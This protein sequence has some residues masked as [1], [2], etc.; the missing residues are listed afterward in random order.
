ML[1]RT[2]RWSAFHRKIRDIRKRNAETDLNEL[3]RIIDK[4]VGQVRAKESGK[5]KQ[6]RKPYPP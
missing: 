2:L 6:T 4:A 5:K 3:Q 1:R